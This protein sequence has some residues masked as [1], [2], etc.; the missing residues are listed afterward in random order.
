MCMEDRAFI[1]D[2]GLPCT[3]YILIKKEAEYN[4]DTK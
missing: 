3:L 2:P 4:D 1:Y